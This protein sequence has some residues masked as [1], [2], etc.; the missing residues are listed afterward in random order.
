MMT[1]PIH[2]TGVA[3]S[4]QRYN[5]TIICLTELIKSS[6]CAVCICCACVILMLTAKIV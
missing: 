6:F 4:S 5:E 3:D 1:A 2:I